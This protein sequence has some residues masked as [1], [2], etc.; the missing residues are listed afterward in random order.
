MIRFTSL[1]LTFAVAI[2]TQALAVPEANTGKLPGLSAEVAIEFDH[3]GIPHI[4]A[5]TWTDAARALG[6]MHASHRLWQMDMFR[7]QASGTSAEVV[8]KP[9]LENDILM[10][11]LGTRRSC[12]ATWKSANL[13]AAF[14]AE[15]EAYSAGVNARIDELK[16]NKLPAMFAM[17]GYEPQPWTPVDSLVFSKYMGWDQSGTNDDLW[18]GMMAEK[19]GVAAVEE[20]WPLDRPY[21]V[22]T[23]KTLAEPAAKSAGAVLRVRPGAADAYA[24]AHARL[25]RVE[26]FGRGGS[27]GSNN[28]AV[29]GS[30]TVSGKPMLCND[31]HLGFKLPSI[32]YACHLSVGGESMAGV[33]FPGGPVMVL[34]HNDHV[35][36]GVTNMQA[37]AV[38]Y[39]V[40]TVDAKDP[41]RYRHRGQWK[42]M[43]HRRESISVR[44][45]KP[46][47]LDID[48]TVH[49]PIISREGR[50]IALEW[51]G[52]RPTQDSVAFWKLSHARNLQDYLRALEDLVV[53]ALNVVFA[54]RQ[55]NIA[56]CPTGD[57]PVRMRG[58][59]RVPMDGASGADD[60]A[61]MIPHDR[62]PQSINP[63]DGFVASANGRPAPTAYPFYL[64]WMW[65]SNY[66]IRRINEL[67]SSVQQLTTNSMASIQLD[68]YDKCA[69]RFLP[70]LLKSL[71]GSASED[72][73][74][75]RAAEELAKW[76]Y[77]TATQSLAPAIWLRWFDHYR[78][79]IWNDEWT[80]R[81]IKQPSGSWGFSGTN[82]RE[83]MLEVLEYMTR[84][85]PQ[86][87]WFDDRSTPERESRDDMARRSFRGAIASLKQEFGADIE[88]WRWGTLNALQIPSLSGLP[89]L[90]RSGGPVV[91]DSFTVNPGGDIGSVD[92]GASWR[93]IVDLA[94]PSTSV[95][96]YPGGQSENPSHAH[97]ADLMPRWAKG[98]YL[99]LYAVG[100]RAR[101]PGEAR[102]SS[103]VL[104]P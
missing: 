20:L 21:E 6:Y 68:A 86:S 71:Q 81:G 85:M 58:Q 3:Y 29:A 12:E 19:L 33:T 57:L 63:P 10:R 69:E 26:L 41:L 84:E 11:Q 4:Y 17:L 39:F 30:K 103:L 90:A 73:L 43:E 72:P 88:K 47:E 76:D 35:A 51:T 25:S 83:P 23:V 78:T 82:R 67:L 61:G 52:L 5:Q 79:A 34:G 87:V 75:K 94:T 74:E 22:P 64:G 9:G 2:S 46:H 101:L 42:Q 44:G 28:W 91:G 77:V 24:I 100:D 62:L 7:R 13:P 36:W 55:G 93:M 102:A 38:D 49:G 32:W 65:D 89:A 1:L 97:Y 50:A 16:A 98:D 8:G 37:D 14:R 80:S 53:P 40:E 48:V 96:V 59:G 54:D 60:W 27:F 70:V 66:R 95:G 104:R 18:F 15:L 99:P 56:I 45:E 31:P 92:S